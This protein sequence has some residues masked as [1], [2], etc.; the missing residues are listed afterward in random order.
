MNK[1]I[2]NAFFIFSVILLLGC[3]KDGINDPAQISN[4]YDS[5][6]TVGSDVLLLKE[7]GIDLE[8]IDGI[9]SIGWNEIFRPFNSEEEVVGS[10]FAVVFGE[11]VGSFP[12]FRR[13][14]IDIGSVFINYNSNQLIMHKH[15]DERKGTAY[16]LFKKPFGRSNDVLEFIPDE[17]Y[18]FE[19]TGSQQF[20]AANF[21][22]NSPETLIEITSHNHKDEISSQQ[23]LTLNWQGGAPD[24]KVAIRLMAHYKG[25]SPHIKG[26][27]FM[28]PPRSPMETIIFIILDTNPGEFTFTTEQV[29]SLLRNNGTHHILA[30]VSQMEMQEIEH[31]GK[32][33]KTVMRN[34]NSV[35]LK[36]K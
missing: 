30:E 26:R 8:G 14:G 13:F 33:I 31:D 5:Y 20:G 28:P 3:S 21:T 35:M 32:I 2:L 4:V 23:D 29:Q 34:G 16:T 11:E 17:D 10:A 24:E 19:I 22:L 15:S 36:V 7:S 25:N 18:V 12:H 6:E 27:P 1:K 9:F